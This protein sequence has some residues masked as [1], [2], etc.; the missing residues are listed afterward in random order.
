VA[1]SFGSTPSTAVSEFQNFEA[2]AMAL[3]IGEDFEG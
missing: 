3:A 2:L 1:F